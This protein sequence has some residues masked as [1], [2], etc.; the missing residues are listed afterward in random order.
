M[1]YWCYLR[2]ARGP[3]IHSRYSRELKIES[4]TSFGSCFVFVT[5]V[6]HRLAPLPPHPPLRT[7]P[8]SLLPPSPPTSLS[9]FASSTYPLLAP[10]PAS[11]PPRL[12][13]TLP[14]SLPLPP[15]T[16]DHS[17]A[18]GCFCPVLLSGPLPRALACVVVVAA[19]PF[20]ATGEAPRGASRAA[21]VPHASPCAAR[22]RYPGGRGGGSSTIPPPLAHTPISPARRRRR[23]RGR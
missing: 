5:Y 13:P 9:P 16:P 3:A 4:I 12:P 11:L 18:V 19:A 1:G 10:L 17:L 20:E 15:L 22:D 2:W 14:P 7:Q 8:S 23:R 6:S 21:A